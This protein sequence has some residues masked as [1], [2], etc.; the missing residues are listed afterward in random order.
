MLRAL[1]LLT[2]ALCLAQQKPVA[3]EEFARALPAV[4]QPKWSP[5]GKR[6]AFE[7]SGAV[8]LYDVPSRSRRELVLLSSLVAKATPAPETAAFD[9]QNRRVAEQSFQWS[10]DGQRLLLSAGGDLF[11]FHLD[12]DRIDQLTATPERER[13][14]KISPDGKYVSFRRDHDLYV[15]DLAARSVRRLTRDGSPTLLN[16]EL[17]WVYPEELD[18]ATAHW[19][20]PDSSRIAFLQFDVSRE[21]A[22]PQVYALQPKAVYEPQLFPQPGTP[23]ADVRLAVVT[24]SGQIRWMDLGDPRD[25]LLARVHWSP[26]SKAVAVQRL[27]RIQSQ[28][29]LLL[30]DAATGASRLVLHEEDAA[31]INVKH[32]FQFL[33]SGER[34]LWGSERDGYRHLYLYSIDGRR[35]SQLTRGDWEVTQLAGVDERARQVFFVSTEA[36]PLERHLYRVGMD[37][38]HKQRITAAPGAHAISMSPVCD[39]F[40]DTYSN[41][42]QPPGATLYDRSG[43]GHGAF[44]EAPKPPAWMLRTEL[45]DF[46]ASDG[47][48]LY[49]RL[50]RPEGY[51][52]GRKYPAIVIIYGGPHAQQ[53]QNAWRVSHIDQFLAH[54][55]FLIWQ[56]DNR[57]SGGRGH[58]WEARIH[59]NLGAAELKDQIDGLRHLDSLGLADMARVGIH[60][61][62]YGG[63]MTLYALAHAPDSFRAGAA[64]APVTD[65]RNYDTIYTERYMGLPEDNAEGYRRSS[66]VTAAANIKARLL[67]LHNAQDDNVHFANTLQMSAALQN[68]GKH[69]ETSIYPQRTHG[70]T[71]PLRN[72]FWQVLADFF[73]RTLK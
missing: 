56:V 6:F 38:K 33:G 64:G 59:R 14:P 15:L 4:P 7:Q 49:A 17:D 22:F 67:L 47:E 21:S 69:F 3:L 10:P 9:W 50:I 65:W 8:W 25:R 39:Y 36:S 2:G 46:R 66:P 20:A 16:A 28:I 57:G 34:F 58:K 51:T 41:A 72:H 45:I 11:L 55:G 44:V 60:G 62:S 71:G 29:D 53:V 54:R 43:E 40:L 32:D 27:N 1:L 48:R 5:G 30:A 63:F 37:G 42:N 52:A 12:G 73:D 68:A 26:N 13:D 24:L 70:V 31:W 61:W 18:L 19:W 35:L 23:N